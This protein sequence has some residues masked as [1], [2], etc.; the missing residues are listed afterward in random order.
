MNGGPVTWSSRKQNIVTLST[1]ESE[2]M[3]A[4]EAAKEIL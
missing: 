1:T 4:S 3:A 2:Y